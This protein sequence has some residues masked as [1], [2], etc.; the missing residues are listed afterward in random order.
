MKSKERISEPP[1]KIDGTKWIPLTKGLFALVDDSDYELTSQFTWT[2]LVCKRTA[3]AYFRRRAAGRSPVTLMHRMLMNAPVGTQVDHIN[4]N[5]L[6]CRRSNMRV[7][8]IAENHRNIRKRI[9][10]TSSRYKGV[11][12]D[13]NRMK[14]MAKIKCDQKFIF[15]GRFTAEES[16][17]RA[18]NVEALRL[19]G[20]FALLNEV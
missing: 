5:G 12:W 15:L 20:K 3:Y 1:E 17:A 11:T 2:A 6:D 19:F 18:Y 7:C 13:K 9:N 10:P 4:S 14:W 8:S 16:A